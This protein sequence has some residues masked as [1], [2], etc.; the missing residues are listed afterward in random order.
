MMKS[1]LAMQGALEDVRTA[2][3]DIDPG[4]D[5]WPEDLFRNL[6]SPDDL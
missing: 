3:L 4:E 6:N 1:R 2:Y 5:G